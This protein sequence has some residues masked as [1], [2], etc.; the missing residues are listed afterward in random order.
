VLSILLLL[1]VEGD[2]MDQMLVVVEV[3]EDLEL[4]Y[5]DIH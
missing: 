5:L 4:M 2:L 1:V 3:P